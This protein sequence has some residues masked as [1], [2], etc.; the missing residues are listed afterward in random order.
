M[1]RV[2]TYVDGLFRLGYFT[3]AQIPA[4][5]SVVLLS[6][7]LAENCEGIS[8]PSTTSLGDRTHLAVADEVALTA[9]PILL[10]VYSMRR[11]VAE[12]LSADHV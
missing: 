9:L 8:L 4:R 5:A 10:A 2:V 12:S 3:G 6:P 1:W 7:A 11:V